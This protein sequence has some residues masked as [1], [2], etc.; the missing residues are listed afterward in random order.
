LSAALRRWAKGLFT[1]EAAVDLL[2]GHGLWTGAERMGRIFG[3]R[4]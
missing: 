1:A 3:Q 2:I 4:S